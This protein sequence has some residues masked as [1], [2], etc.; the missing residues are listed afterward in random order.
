MASEEF[1]LRGLPYDSPV[2]AAKS[3]RGSAFVGILATVAEVGDE[4]SSADLPLVR[5]VDLREALELRPR[6]IAL[7]RK[8]DGEGR[9][10]TELAAP[11][12]L[13]EKG[14]PIPSEARAFRTC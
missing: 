2:A 1:P 11:E 9:S 12:G 10:G 8:G 5:N 13:D 6:L 14:L 4:D 7:A 3:V